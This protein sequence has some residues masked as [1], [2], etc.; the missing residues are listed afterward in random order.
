MNYSLEQRPLTGILGE[1]KPDYLVPY[2]IQNERSDIRAHVCVL[3]QIVYVYPT[4]CGRKAI[5]SKTYQGKP[6]SQKGYDGATAWGYA[7]PVDDIERMVSMRVSHFIPLFG[8]QFD[9][10]TS[11]KGQKAVKLVAYMLRNGLFP[12]FVDPEVILD[13]EMQITGTDINVRSSHRI[14]VKCDYKGGKGR[15]CTGNLYLQTDEIN[16]FKRV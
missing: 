8:F 9:D 6:A 11:V 13:A 2:G 15:G 1:T 12:L 3:A 16:P 10:I 5:E 14:Q 7:V 4:V